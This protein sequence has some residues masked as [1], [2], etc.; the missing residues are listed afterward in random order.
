[1]F[2][3]IQG[4]TYAQYR[5]QSAGRSRLMTYHGYALADFQSENRPICFTRCSRKRFP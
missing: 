2:G 5:Q 3:I 1:L 4:G